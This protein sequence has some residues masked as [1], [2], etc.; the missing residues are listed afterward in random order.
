MLASHRYAATLC[1][2]VPAGKNNM[3]VHW[4]QALYDA[5]L[6]TKAVGYLRKILFKIVADRFSNVTAEY[7]LAYWKRCCQWLVG[8][9]KR[10]FNTWLVSSMVSI[11]LVSI[12]WCRGA[13]RCLTAPGFELLS[14]GY[15][16][17]KVPRFLSILLPPHK[18]NRLLGTGCFT[19]SVSGIGSGTTT[20]T[21]IRL[22]DRQS[23]V[24]TN[25][26]NSPFTLS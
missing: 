8:R 23:L 10:M 6:C 12:W 22:L 26:E 17:S 3:L 13:R 14:S 21:R 24:C 20:L 1:P 19:P 25:L 18:S 2:S 11:W 7:H 16:L 15:S 5:F 9:I 4:N